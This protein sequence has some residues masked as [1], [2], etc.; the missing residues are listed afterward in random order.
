MSVS[1]YFFGGYHA[2]QQDIDKWLASAKQ[3]AP[4]MEFLGF[5]WPDGAPSWPEKDVITGARKLIKFAIETIKECS[6]NAEKIYILGH[7]SGCAIANQVDRELQK[8]NIVLVALDGYSPREDQLKR[9]STQVWGADCQD[10]KSKNYPGPSMGRQQI[11]HATN[12]TELWS[13]HFSLVN[14]NA[15]NSSVHGIPTGYFNCK[16]NMCWLSPK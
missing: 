2:S 10:K 11:Y 14:A 16:A 13:L 8:T 1:V 4:N 5:P 9:T 6:A 3:Q 15:S 7:S 12:C